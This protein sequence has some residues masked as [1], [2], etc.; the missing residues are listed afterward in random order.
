MGRGGSTVP[1]TLRCRPVG[2]SMKP[3]QVAKVGV[4]SWRC[5]GRVIY[6]YRAKRRRGCIPASCA[7]TSDYLPTVM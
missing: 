2:I 6:M 3:G 4:V 1:S 5:G 7:H